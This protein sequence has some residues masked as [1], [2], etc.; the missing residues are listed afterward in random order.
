[1]R[2]FCDFEQALAIRNFSFLIVN[3]DSKVVLYRQKIIRVD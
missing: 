3:R 1:M 2:E